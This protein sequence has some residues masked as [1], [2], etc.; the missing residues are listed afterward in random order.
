[1]NVNSVPNT[2]RKSIVREGTCLEKERVS[3]EQPNEHSVSSLNLQTIPESC[4]TST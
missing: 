4:E 2:V 1:M 3:R